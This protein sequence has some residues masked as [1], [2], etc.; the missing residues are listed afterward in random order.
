MLES[1]FNKVAGLNACNFIKKR[2]HYSYFPVKFAKFLRT[3]S[4]TEHFRR[5]LLLRE[6]H[7]DKKTLVKHVSPKNHL[8]I[9]NFRILKGLK[10]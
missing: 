3:P 9:A 2:L 1:L 10:E 7:N 4:Y 6:K 8:I 5:L